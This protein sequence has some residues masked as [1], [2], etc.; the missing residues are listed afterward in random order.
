MKRSKTRFAFEAMGKIHSGRPRRV[1]GISLSR[2]DQNTSHVTDSANSEPHRDW[3]CLRIFAF[4][5]GADEPTW[6]TILSKD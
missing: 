2:V 6:S 1:E 5:Y 3:C 4:E